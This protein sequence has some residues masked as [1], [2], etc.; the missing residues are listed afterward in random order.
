MTKDTKD[1][2]VSLVS[3]VVQPI[4]AQIIPDMIADR[5]VFGVG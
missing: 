1:F 4:L 5:A 3:F 2:F